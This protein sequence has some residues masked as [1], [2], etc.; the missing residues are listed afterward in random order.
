MKKE[1][2]K[3]L[4]ALANIKAEEQLPMIKRQF[5]QRLKKTYNDKSY[6]INQTRILNELNRYDL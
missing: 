4:K 5:Y 1:F 6:S 3:K 2:L